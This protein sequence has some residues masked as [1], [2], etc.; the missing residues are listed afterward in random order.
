MKQ[1]IVV[2]SHGTADQEARQRTLEDFM[3][4]IGDRLE[5][6]EIVSAFT[7]S[8]VRR[9]LREKS[10]EKVQNVKAA[11]LSMKEKGI[12]HLTIVTTE[13]I[14]SFGNKKLREEISGLAGFF[15]EVHIT[16]PLISSSMDAEI[17]ARAFLG[18]FGDIIG[19][20]TL[21]VIAEDNKTVYEDPEY[22]EMFFG[23]EL[24]DKPLECLQDNLRKVIPNSYVASVH[25]SRKLYKVIKEINA[26]DNQIDNQ[27]NESAG[28]VSGEPERKR[29]VLIP[30]EFIA[31]EVIEN[32]VSREFKGLITRLQE[33]GYTV[34]EYF[35]GLGEYDA[36]Q[37][38][39]LRHLYDVR[40]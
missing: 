2:V 32:E 18:A 31:G 16:K 4:S 12:T 28:A 36:F 11:I 21:I 29:I 17:T 15:K 14:E 22:S 23:E 30:L 40:G 3:L 1:G 8:D 38:L 19:D 34:E 7:D 26:G 13:I 27:S 6:A 20:D 5:E 35:K 10:G 37:R 39:Y 25:G 33:E 24:F 9:M